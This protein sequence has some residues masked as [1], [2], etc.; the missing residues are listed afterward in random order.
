MPHEGLVE[1]FEF[2]ILLSFTPSNVSRLVFTEH[3]SHRGVLEQAFPVLYF[4]VK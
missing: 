4:L 2:Y 3:W 1:D